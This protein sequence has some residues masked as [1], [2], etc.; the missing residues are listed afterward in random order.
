MKRENKSKQKISS[1]SLCMIL[2]SL[3]FMT[4][5]CE[6]KVSDEEPI[7]WSV[8]LK[9]KPQT[10]E[11]YLP[12]EDPVIKALLL[13]HG[14]KMKQTFP[15]AKNPEQLLYYDLTVSGNTDKE[16]KERFIK[17]FLATGKF[18]DDVYEYGIAHAC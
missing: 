15:G 5:G 8:R 6:K 11:S 13:K 7:S 16:S 10:D 17:D 14:V 3:F 18:E 1:V 4:L 12:T 2:C 9:L